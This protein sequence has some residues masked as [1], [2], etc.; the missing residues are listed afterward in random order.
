MKGAFGLIGLLLALLIVGVLVRQQLG[1]TRGAIPVAPTAGQQPTTVRETSQQVQQQ[2]EQSV[3]GALQS[4][5][6][7]PEDK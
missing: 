4:A 5:R 6:P 3:Q 2:V 7:M 1:A